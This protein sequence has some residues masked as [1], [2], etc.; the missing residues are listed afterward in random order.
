M[1]LNLNSILLY[2]FTLFY[3]VIPHVDLIGSAVVF[4][5]QQTNTQTIS[6]SLSLCVCVWGLV[7]CCGGVVCCGVWL[8]VFVCV[9]FFWSEWVFL[10]AH[11]P[12]CLAAL[13][14]SKL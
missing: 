10:C 3:S 8:C 12:A 4:L 11:A 2:S 5:I 7:W 9:L 1:V 14:F 13:Y 6:L